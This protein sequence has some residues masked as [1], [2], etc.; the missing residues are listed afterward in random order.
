[1]TVLGW[2]VLGLVAVWGASL[3]MGSGAYGLVGDIPAGILGGVVGGWLGSML[4]GIDATG[5]N[6]SSVAVAVVGAVIAIATFRAV[7]PDR[8]WWQA[9]Q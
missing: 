1:M 5:V 9:W 3:L 6:L 4:L 7:A 8:P 2:I